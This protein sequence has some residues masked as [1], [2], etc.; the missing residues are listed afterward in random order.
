MI[1]FGV[2]ACGQHLWHFYFVEVFWPLCVCVC[3]TACAENMNQASV[4]AD[5]GLQTS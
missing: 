4:M 1:T 2:A 3:L 5:I